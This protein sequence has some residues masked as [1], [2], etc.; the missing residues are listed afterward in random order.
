[1]MEMG[2]RRFPAAQRHSHCA[3][4]QRGSVGALGWP[5]VAL[6]GLFI[7]GAGKTVELMYE[8]E[9]LL[10]VDSRW[11]Q[12]RATPLPEVTGVMVGWYLRHVPGA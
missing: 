1:M 8:F 10:V 3:E 6:T 4:A 5:R 2:L 11:F 12:K 9:E 7:P